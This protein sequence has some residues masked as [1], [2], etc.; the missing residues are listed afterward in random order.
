MRH[1]PFNINLIYTYKRFDGESSMAF[2]TRSVLTFFGVLSGAADILCFKL[3]THSIFDGQNLRSAIVII[4][5]VNFSF[6]RRAPIV[7]TSVSSNL[8]S[9]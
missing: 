2:V 7:S 1:I 8:K 5:G 3:S 9:R 6:R 4:D